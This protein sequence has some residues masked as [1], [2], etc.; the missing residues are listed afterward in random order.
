MH[1]ALKRAVKLE[2]KGKL[3]DFNQLH[4]MEPDSGPTNIRNVKSKQWTRWLGAQNRCVVPFNS[5]SEFNK[6]E[7]GDI[8]F[9]LY[10]SCPLAC[11]AGILDVRGLN[12][13]F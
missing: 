8:C 13:R 3:V 10:D 9:T 4:R 7:G 12:Q 2:A 6:A 1:S 5:S 11:F